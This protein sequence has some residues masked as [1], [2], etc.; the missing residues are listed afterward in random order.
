MVVAFVQQNIGSEHCNSTIFSK[1]RLGRML[2]CS[3]NR[4]VDISFHVWVAQVYLTPIPKLLGHIAKINDR[5][6]VRPLIIFTFVVLS[7][8]QHF[9]VCHKTKISLLISNEH[10][11]ET[12]L[13]KKGFRPVAGAKINWLPSC[14]LPHATVVYMSEYMFACRSVSV[15][16]TYQQI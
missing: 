5:R 16:D 2:D 11:P 15:N 14:V 9:Y 6:I 13:Y 3:G 8:R 4:V 7:E 1:E 10:I 12:M